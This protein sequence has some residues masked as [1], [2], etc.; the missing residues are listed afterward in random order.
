LRGYF[1]VRRKRQKFLW[2]SNVE[3]TRNIVSCC[4]KYGVKNLVFTSSNCLWAQNFHR[5]VCE[6]DVPNPLEIYGRSKLEGEKILQSY[7]AFV[8]QRH[9]TLPH[10]HG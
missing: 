8:N 4:K 1:G 9:N 6:D 7:S 5:P 2:N 10:Y 3:G